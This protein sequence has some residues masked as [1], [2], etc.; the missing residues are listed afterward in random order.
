M[1]MVKKSISV[2]DQQSDW[3]KT[4]IT[5]GHYGNESEV[6]RELIRERQLREQETT[7]EISAIRAKLLAAEKRDASTISA[8][9][10]LSEIKE[11]MRRNGQ[12]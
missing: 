1:S 8:E 2:T 7:S 6:I 12:L 4:Q 11:E 9:A 3:M 10:L 5:T